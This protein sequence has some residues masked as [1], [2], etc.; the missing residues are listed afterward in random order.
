MKRCS[1][2]IIV[3]ALVAM[4]TL[5]GGFTGVASADHDVDVEVED[6]DVKSTEVKT[7]DRVTAEVTVDN[8]E[9]DDQ[10]VFVGFSV[11]G[12]DGTYYDNDGSTGQVIEL[13]GYEERTVEVSWEVPEDAPDGEYD[14]VSSV[15]AETDRNDLETRLGSERVSDAFTVETSAADDEN[16]DWW[17]DETT[18]NDDGSDSWGDTET[19]TDV[20]GDTAVNY[21]YD[22][23]QRPS[24]SLSM[25]TAVSKTSEADE[26][27]TSEVVLLN[28]G[29][30]EQMFY[31]QIRLLGPNNEFYRPK[32]QS[33]YRSFK[34]VKVGSESAEIVDLEWTLWT[35]APSGEYDVTV[36]VWPEHPS[37]SDVALDS[38]HRYNAVTYKNEAAD[39]PDCMGEIQRMQQLTQSGLVEA[40]FTG[41]A[42]ANTV[43]ANCMAS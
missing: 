39:D 43:V 30:D 19:T 14:V 23:K 11:V 9:W 4:S 8:D 6:V 5:L 37:D 38:I 12:P 28:T 1:K 22:G 41:L 29:R 35:T 20:P 21:G 15:W 26:T 17:N 34:Q 13:D 3:A 33:T 10:R 18:T 24:A 40:K 36:I 27:I 25:F 32:L 16:D 7:D 31:V 42:Y 2:A